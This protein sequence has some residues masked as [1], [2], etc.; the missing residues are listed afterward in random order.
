MRRQT[1]RCRVDPVLALDQF[2]VARPLGPNDLDRRVT[3]QGIY[4]SLPAPNGIPWSEYVRTH[5]NR[6]QSISSSTE[7]LESDHARYVTSTIAQHA[8]SMATCTRSLPTDSPIPYLQPIERGYMSE[9]SQ[10]GIT[11]Y[12]VPSEHTNN[13]GGTDYHSE[14]TETDR[15]STFTGLDDYDTLFTAR[16]GRG[17]LDPAPKTGETKAMVATSISP[18]TIGPELINPMERTLSVQED[19]NLYQREQMKPRMASPSAEIIGEGAAI[20]TD[21]TETILDILDK[22][23]LMSPDS[24]QTIKEIPNKDDQKV[25]VHSTQDIIPETS[26]QREDY[27]DLFLPI[28]EIYRISDCFRGYSESLSA[29]NNP[30]VLLEL[31]NLSYRYGTSLYAVDR[32]KGTMYGKFSIG[33]RMIPEKATD[34]TSIPTYFYWG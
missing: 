20:F 15:V 32:V 28:R 30:M 12:R 29:D 14:I 8:R 2:S 13:I 19:A 22:Q 3:R 21:M 6:P 24:Q 31:N 11:P 7:A 16:H 27:P 1:V 4:P 25:V 18:P 9:G 5:R 34:N 33:Y 10:E 26:T 17:A 23:V